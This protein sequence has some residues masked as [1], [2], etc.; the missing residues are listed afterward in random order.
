MEK[1]LSKTTSVYIAFHL[2]SSINAA[3]DAA[4]IAVLLGET[5][6]VEQVETIDLDTQDK[7]VVYRIAKPILHDEQQE[8][9]F[10]KQLRELFLDTEDFHPHFTQIYG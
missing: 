4:R 6:G 5:F 7:E 1:T 2:K 10:F 8:Q 9:D 3:T